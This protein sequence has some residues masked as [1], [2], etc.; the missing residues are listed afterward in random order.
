VLITDK[1]WRVPV[2]LKLLEGE[3]NIWLPLIEGSLDKIM[4]SVIS[5]DA[6]FWPARAY[7]RIPTGPG[8]D[9]FEWAERIMKNSPLDLGCLS[10][11]VS[12]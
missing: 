12:S 9:T 1:G 3:E 2:D 10:R 11:G 6:E 5:I 7:F 8:Y 4:P